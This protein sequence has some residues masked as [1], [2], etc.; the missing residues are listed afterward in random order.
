[1]NMRRKAEVDKVTDQT[2]LVEIVM[3]DK[4]IDLRYYAIQRITDQTLLTK[5]AL[6][7]SSGIGDAARRRCEELCAEAEFISEGDSRELAATKTVISRYFPNQGYKAF[8]MIDWI[9]TRGGFLNDLGLATLSRLIGLSGPTLFVFGGKSASHEG[10]LL[11]LLN[12]GKVALIKAEGWFELPLQAW[13]FIV[14]DEIDKNGQI[15]TILM[16]NFIGARSSALVN[17]TGT[18]GYDNH[19]NARVFFDSLAEF[20]RDPN[21]ITKRCA[22]LLKRKRRS[23][24]VLC[25]FI[26]F[27]IGMVKAAF[28]TL[29]VDDDGAHNLALMFIAL[30][31]VGWMVIEMRLLAAVV[32]AKNKFYNSM[33]FWEWLSFYFIGSATLGIIPAVIILVMQRKAAKEIQ[34]IKAKTPSI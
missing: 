13:N 34:L 28:R 10:G 12:D 23:G 8:V 17:V 33:S 25:A 3:K 9:V 1:M 4:D 26:L 19:V 15:S 5:I 30:P 16:R 24:Y 32:Y 20:E 22:K 7:D 11:V 14:P 6:Q 31:V 27:L 21:E 18:K 2:L 29:P